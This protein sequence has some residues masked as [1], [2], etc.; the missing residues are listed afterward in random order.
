VAAGAR[1][2]I[3][4]AARILRLITVK[5][6]KKLIESV[7]TVEVLRCDVH[8]TTTWECGRSLIIPDLRETGI[9]YGQ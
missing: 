8:A 4:N 9:G 3:I 6:A 1:S 2:R 5:A 7:S